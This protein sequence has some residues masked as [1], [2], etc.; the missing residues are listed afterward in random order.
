MA[1]WFPVGKLVTPV[2]ELPGLPWSVCVRPCCPECDNEMWILYSDDGSTMEVWCEGCGHTFRSRAVAP[3]VIGGAVV[4][5]W[6]TQ[7]VEQAE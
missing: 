4:R 1:D 6:M 2:A 7:Q 3:G 5:A